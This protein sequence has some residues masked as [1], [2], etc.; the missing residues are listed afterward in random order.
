MTLS[1]GN[2]EM[3]IPGVLRGGRFDGADHG[4]SRC[5]KAVDF[6]LELADR[7][8]YIELKDPQHPRIDRIERATRSSRGCTAEN[9]TRT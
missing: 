6:V 7:Y 1:E 2:L 8:L 4:L 5:M 9:W 3:E